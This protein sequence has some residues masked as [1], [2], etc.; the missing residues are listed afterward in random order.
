LSTEGLPSYR[1]HQF[2]TGR[3]QTTGKPAEEKT[4]H[5][6]WCDFAGHYWEFSGT[7]IRL[8]QAEATVCTCFDHGV[9]MEEGDH[10][11][12]RVELLSCPEH[13][14]DQ[15]RAM[16]Y[17]PDYVLAQEPEDDEHSMFRDA[18][19]NHTI[20]FCL[21]CG[22]D[23]YTMADHET[24]VSNE[25]AA[26]PVFQKLK[27]QTCEPQLEALLDEADSDEPKKKQ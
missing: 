18:S 27:D 11:E 26:C 13:R 4:V 14:A 25:M 2:Q 8:F 19:G 9:P 20:G 15:M 22:C 12:C 5:Q 1:K 3:K 6:H 7:A 10:S 17:E 21:W 24:H 23:F 16:G